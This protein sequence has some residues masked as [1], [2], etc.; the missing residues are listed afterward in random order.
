MS[1]TN[2]SGAGRK[3]LGG[4][5]GVAAGAIFALGVYLAAQTLQPNSGLILLSVLLIPAAAS[6]LAVLVAGIHGKG[7]A[8]PAAVMALVVV[9][10]LMVGAA[11]FLREGAICLAMAAP[12]F[13]PLG[14]I[15]ALAATYLR[16]RFG[17]SR[18]PPAMVVLLPV[19]LLPIEQP[20]VYPTMHETVVTHIEI[21]A[22]IDVVWRQA[23]EIRDITADE[24]SW[25][26]TQDMLRIPRPLDARL[27]E[28]EGALVRAAAWRGG[29]RFYEVVTDWRPNQS[30]AWTFDIPESAADRLLDEHLRLDQAYLRLESG[31]YE[32]EALSPS[33]TRLTLRTRYMVRTPFN[34]YARAWGEL[35]LGDIHRNVLHVVGERA[36]AQ[37]R[38]P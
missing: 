3:W 15:G 7:S 12:F 13:F 33:R 30:V 21:D 24:Q 18:T 9:S 22:P 11:I 16:G 1:Q 35:L 6:A 23:V 8:G 20:S 29:V 27:V 2:G 17:G 32:V 38:S 19:L 28:R 37:G 25:T 10:A 14:V 31:G 4:A 36:E 26:I 5:V 34:L